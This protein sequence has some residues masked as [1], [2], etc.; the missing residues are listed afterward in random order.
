MA[1]PAVAE[2]GP[3]ADRLEGLLARLPTAADDMI[4][5]EAIQEIARAGE[6][7]RDSVHQ[8]VMDV[9]KRLNAMQAELAQQRLDGAAVYDIDEADGPLIAAFMAGLNRTAPLKF[10]HPGL[11]ATALA[12]AMREGSPQLEERKRGHVQDYIARTT[13]RALQDPD[14]VQ[15]WTRARSQEHDHGR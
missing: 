14:V 11:D 15:A 8:F 10:D 13:S 3:F 9:H 4:Q 5:G 6:G 2:K 12:Q 7:K 1:A